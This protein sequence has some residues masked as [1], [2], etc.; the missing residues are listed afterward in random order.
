MKFIERPT[1]TKFSFME[2]DELDFPS[3]TFCNTNMFRIDKLLIKYGGWTELIYIALSEI[4]RLFPQLGITDRN[5][6]GDIPEYY[7]GNVSLYEFILTNGH[8]REDSIKLCRFN[9]KICGPANFTTTVTNYGVCYTFNS[10]SSQ[11]SLSVQTPGEARG[12]SVLLNAEQSLHVAAPRENAGFKMLVHPKD[13]F[14]NLQD[15]GL[16][17]ELGTHSAVRIATRKLEML[18]SPH[19]TCVKDEEQQLEYLG[20]YTKS[21]CLIECETDFI[22]DNCG[23]RTYYMPGSAPFCDPRNLIECFHVKSDEFNG[24][25]NTVCHHCENSCKQTVYPTTV[26]QSTFPSYSVATALS[27]LEGHTYQDEA[28]GEKLTGVATQAFW[29]ESWSYTHGGFRLLL[30][31]ATNKNGERFQESYPESFD[32][33][34]DNISVTLFSMQYDIFYALAEYTFLE[35]SSYFDASFASK[36]YI[37]ISSYMASVYG[38]PLKQR[39]ADGIKHEYHSKTQNVSFAQFVDIV[40]EEYNME[41]VFYIA[42]QEVY[43][44][45]HEILLPTGRRIYES[46]DLKSLTTQYLRENMVHV[47]IFFGDLK[48]EEIKEQVDYEFF[49]FI[50]DWGGALGLFFGASLLSFIETMDFCCCRRF[51]PKETIQK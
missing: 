50:C 8:E 22:V 34:I 5:I 29:A 18:P 30:G 19:G 32:F 37:E 2:E 14:P 46:I 38:G 20:N 28:F 27:L 24:I 10:I 1:N 42:I 3:V 16:E 48:V 45:M 44:N 41:D 25:K 12:L 35:V 40:L 11:Q 23:C 47:D 7:A 31:N 36:T 33:I 4:R 17:L 43:Q 26:S 15:F 21:K 51:Y 39:F 13:E 9:G 49:Q 6:D